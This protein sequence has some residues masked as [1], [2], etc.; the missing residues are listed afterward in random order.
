MEL[1]ATEGKKKLLGEWNKK[2]TGLDKGYEN[3]M[4]ANKALTILTL[5]LPCVGQKWPGLYIPTSH[6]HQIQDAWERGTSFKVGPCG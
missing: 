4:W 1:G 5:E 6:I 3:M 2:E